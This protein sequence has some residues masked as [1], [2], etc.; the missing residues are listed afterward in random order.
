MRLLLWRYF[1]LCLYFGEVVERGVQMHTHTRTH[2][3]SYD[4][5]YTEEEVLL[6][7]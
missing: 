4:F 5:Y 6:E 7:T 3:L 2:R 1:L